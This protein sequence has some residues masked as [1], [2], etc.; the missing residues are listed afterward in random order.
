[1]TSIVRWCCLCSLRFLGC[2]SARPFRPR[3][4]SPQVLRALE[5]MSMPR[6]TS[7][8]PPAEVKAK[9]RPTKRV[10]EWRKTKLRAP[11]TT[12]GR[13]AA[14]ADR[15]HLAKGGGLRG[16]E[17]GRGGSQSQPMRC[18]EAERVAEGATSAAV[19]VRCCL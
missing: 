12:V 9:G 19:A 15:K 13:G 18:E 10:T 17:R 5:T 7:K 6:P 14:L 2:R 11:P 3:L 16:T 1:M 8:A 4:H